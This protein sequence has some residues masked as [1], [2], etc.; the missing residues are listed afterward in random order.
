MR[1]EPPF[2]IT[3]PAEKPRRVTLLQAPLGNAPQPLQGLQ[4][5]L[6]PPEPWVSQPGGDG[7]TP[8]EF[9]LTGNAA[10]LVQRP[11]CPVPEHGWQ[12]QRPWAGG[13][14]RSEQM[15]PAQRCYLTVS[16]PSTIFSSIN[17]SR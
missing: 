16:M 2:E 10:Q 9:W 7:S 13:Q 4:E 8:A 11:P 6:N 14:E 17:L 1:Q 5:A 12:P 3:C 15:V